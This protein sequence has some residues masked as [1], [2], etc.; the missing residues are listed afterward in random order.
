MKPIVEGMGLSW[1]G[2]HEKL[3]ANKARWTIKEILMV[4]EDG[5]MREQSC[6]PLRKLPGWMGT[7]HPNKVNPE[8]RD[9]II[10]YQNECDDVLWQHWTQSR[11]SALPDFDDEIVAAEAFI[12]ERKARRIAEREREEA[13]REL[14]ASLPKIAFHDQVVSSETLM[15]FAQMFG[16][17]QHKTGQRFTRTSFL[18]FARRHGVACQPNPHNGITAGRFVP[19]RDY[20]GTWFVSEMHSNGVTEWMVRP[21]AVAGIVALVEMERGGSP[22]A[23][24]P[25]QEAA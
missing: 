5:K 20:V 19:R 2:Q 18:A 9:G 15:D 3:S 8:I 13:R 21:M 7:V 12:A 1:Q 11:P 23:G 10:A 16:L 17:L 25:G 24:P 14:E 4:A 6:M 22:F